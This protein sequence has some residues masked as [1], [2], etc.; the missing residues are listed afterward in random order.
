MPRVLSG[1]GLELLAQTTTQTPQASASSLFSVFPAHVSEAIV[2]HSW[3]CRLLAL[4]HTAHWSGSP[5]PPSGLEVHQK[6]SQNST[7]LA[8][9]QYSERTE[10]KIGQGQRH[11]G[12]GPGASVPRLFQWSHTD[13]A[14]SSQQRC[15]TTCRLVSTRQASWRRFLLKVSRIFY[16]G[17]SPSRGSS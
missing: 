17:S 12:Q 7:Q 1:S 3:L 8:D 6:G 10:I 9:S 11:T 5:R 16:S 15:V 4:Y 14:Q 2:W 13:S